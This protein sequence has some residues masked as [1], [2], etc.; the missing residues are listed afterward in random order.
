M[1]YGIVPESNGWIG[2]VT[3]G[4]VG[5]MGSWKRDRIYRVLW[6]IALG[7]MLIGFVFYD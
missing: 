4:R 1:L 6:F 2:Y 7:G 5:L 3:R